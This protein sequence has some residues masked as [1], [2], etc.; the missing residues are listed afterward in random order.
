MGARYGASVSGDSLSARLALRAYTI[1]PTEIEVGRN[2]V[3]ESLALGYGKEAVEVARAL[4]KLSPEDAGL[5]ANRALALLIADD[6][7]GARRDVTKA[8]EL[9]P[10]DPITRD[11]RQ[12]IEDVSAGRTAR[13]MKSPL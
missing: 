3:M 6:V 2:L 12:L 11:L 10:G 5:R 9:A 1:A 8:L 7:D 4:E 13:P